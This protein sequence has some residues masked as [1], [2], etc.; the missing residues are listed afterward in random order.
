MKTARNTGALAAMIAI[1][2]T[3]TAGP[4]AAQLHI[5]A[6]ARVTLLSRAYNTAGQQ[7]FGQFAASPGNIVFSPYSIGTAMSMLI[8]GARGDT[9]SEMM[10]AMSMRM[11]ADAIDAANAEMLSILNGYDQSAAPPVCPPRTTANGANCESRPGGELMNQC[12]PGFRLVGNRCVAPGATPASARFLAANALMLLKRG[13]LISADYVAALK[14]K[15]AAEV[16]R[17][18]SLDDING[19]VARKTEGKIDRM[20]DRIDPDSA[21]TILNAV[22][23]KAR[24]ASVFDPKLTKDEPFDLTRSQKAEVALM[25]QTGSF[26]LVSRGGY[27]AIRLNYQI[28]ELGLVVVLPDDIEGVGAVGRRLGANELAE[29]F[30]ALRDGQAKKPVALALPRFK[31]EYRAELVGPFRQAGIRKAFDANSADF[32]G[33]TGR[34]AGQGQIHVDQIVHRAVIEVAEESTEAAAATAIGIRSA[35][36]APVAPVSF[37]VDHPYLFYL[38]DDTSGAILFQG[39][40]VD[41]R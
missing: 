27:R 35:A 16:F 20:L 7:L 15:Y 8:S 1:A 41:P 36:I 17:D 38:V 19:W 26:S 23:F 40:V 31:A 11:A 6:E 30:A 39:R 10:R 4:A 33:M 2:A 12:Q 37:R 13:D 22:Y 25:N 5:A 28:P 32:S 29:L 14:T 21:A 24:W 18:A 9:A 34:P 3:M